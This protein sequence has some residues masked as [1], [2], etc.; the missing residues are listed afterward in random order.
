MVYDTMGNG[1]VKYSEILAE[2]FH[3]LSLGC[4]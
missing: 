3:V 2:I 4:I 1:L